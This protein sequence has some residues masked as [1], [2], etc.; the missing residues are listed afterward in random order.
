MFGFLKRWR[1]RRLARK[2]FPQPW[3]AHLEEH[4]PFYR[5]LN[6]TTKDT[7][8]DK[9][10]VFVWEKNWEGAQGFAVTDEHKVVI[11]AAAIRLVLALDLSYYDRIV[12]IVIYPG[13]YRH[14]DRDGGTVLG[15]VNQWGAVCLS[16]PAVVSG[17]KRPTDGLDTTVH[18]F[19]H[20]LDLADGSFDGLPPL[21]EMAHVQ[22]WIDVMQSHYDQLQGRRSRRR[23]LIRD[24][25]KT[26]PAEFFAVIS[27]VFFE[28]P[29]DLN[30]KLP[31]LFDELRQ[32]YGWDPVTGETLAAA[33]VRRSGRPS[34]RERN[35]AKRRR[36]ERDD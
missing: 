13:H 8:R 28:K 17:L 31:D 35:R 6:D 10:K 1:R 11:S 26:N 25:G 16:W 9:L 21:R 32:F 14:P 24:Y 30:E 15:Q 20:A 22:P 12:S 7:F 3:H 5:A 19:A 29:G 4:V 27:E 36:R 2:P 23:S 33:A 18:E 34:R